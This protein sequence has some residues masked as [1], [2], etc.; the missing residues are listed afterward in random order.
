M[1]ADDFAIIPFHEGYEVEAF[2][3]DDEDLSEFLTS[4][5][6]ANYQR[7]MLGKTYL[8]YRRDPWELVAYYTVA[9]DRL[10]IP[11]DWIKKSMVHS[12]DAKIFPAV[13]LGRF[14]VQQSLHGTGIGS[15]LLKHVFTEAMDSNQAVRFVRLVAHHKSIRFYKKRGFAFVSDKDEEKAEDPKAKPRMFF[16][17]AKLPEDFAPVRIVHMEL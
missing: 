5:Q 4:E 8:V 1:D 10:D 11:K 9:S 2:D 14:A 13:L 17:L 6:V 16:D 15:I 12:R 7:D 3:C